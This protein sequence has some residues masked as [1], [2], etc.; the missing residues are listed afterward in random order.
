[1]RSL[2]YTAAVVTAAAITVSC[3]DTC[4]ENRNA[5]PLAGFYA[6]GGSSEKISIDSVEVIGVG[7]AGDSVLSPATG[8][9]NE[10]YM[11]FKVD[12]DT[13]AYAFIDIRAGSTLRDTVTFIYSRTPRF[14]NVECGVSYIFELKSI[15]TSGRMI[16]S[17][18]CPEGY[19][20]NVN[21]EN[22]RIYFKVQQQEM[23]P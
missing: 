12:S 14:V 23:Q 9:K 1:M 10:L 18:I 22:L 15:S 19:I 20:D 4:S 21:T 5:L 2:L 8:Y 17:V 11:P 13:T 7:V 16:D 3:S 6:S